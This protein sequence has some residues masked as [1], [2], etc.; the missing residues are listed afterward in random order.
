MKRPSGSMLLARGVRQLTEA[1]VPDAPRDARRLLAHAAGVEA[2]RLTLILPE[3]VSVEAEAEFAALLQRRCAREPVS[4]L[5]GTRMFYGRQF[6]VN[7]FVLDPRPETEILVEAA[8]QR[9]FARVLDLGTG[10]G[11]ILLTLLAEVP[12]AV[13]L[14]ADLSAEA[15]TV[16]ERNAQALGLRERAQFVR[17]NW[18]D[19]IEES[20]DLLV[21]NPPYIALAEMPD[22][23]PEVR[24]FEPEMA[25]TDGADG[26]EAYRAIAEG[27][28]PLRTGG[29]A[30]FE[31]GPTQGQAVKAIFDAKGFERIEIIKDL[32]GRDRVV[33]C[34]GKMDDL[35]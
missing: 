27:L 3:P 6:E 30:F 11:C 4:H 19:A 7:R 16:A 2:G 14:G 26:L 28:H 29:D 20:F 35:G 25:L 21:S 23:S 10:S 17:S 31:I 9:S 15:I 12:E 24:E 18:S 34:Y 8:L 22:L 5:I 1:G 33:A 32:D 13:G